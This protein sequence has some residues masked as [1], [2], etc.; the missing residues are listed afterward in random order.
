ME[1]LKKYVT[2]RNLQIAT[3]IGTAFT[4][5]MFIMSASIG[6]N[7]ESVSSFSDIG[8]LISSLKT[9]CN[10][11]YLDFIVVL[12]TTAGYAFRIFSEKDTRLS[13]K[14]LT[15]LNGIACL[16]GLI[17]FSTIHSIKAG[18]S[19]DF[20]SL[21]QLG[22]IEGQFSILRIMLFLQIAAGIAAAYFLFYKKE[23]RAEQESVDEEKQ[24]SANHTS[25][26]DSI[27][28][29]SATEK[30]KRNIRIGG[31]AAG[32]IIVLIVIV[33][34]Y[35][36]NRRTEIDLTTAC[37]VTF[38]GVSGSGSA[39]IHCSPDYDH[40]NEKIASF[41]SD[42]SYTIDNNGSLEN[43]T[44]VTLKANYSEA[45]AESSKINPVKTT[46]KYKVKGLEIAYRNFA[47]IPEKVSDEFEGAA[48]AFLEKDI[49]DVD[50]IFGGY[51][52]ITVEETALIGIYYK[53]GSYDNSGT[54]YYVFR[55]KETRE[56]SSYTKKEV[57]YYTV[58]LEN[59]KSSY[60]LDLSDESEDMIIDTLSI[61]ENDKTDAKALKQFTRFH[62]NVETVKTSPGSDIYKDERI[63]KQS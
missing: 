55:T 12:T 46:K 47:D 48:K 28:A 54:A 3:L 2:D 44:E 15:P 26:A 32:I 22:D 41:M 25:I 31:A 29:Y 59:I 14:V 56:R 19:G 23:H 63:D 49:Q 34:V 58:I 5:M 16:F 40:N 39:S 27:K 53:Y 30:G 24:A 62:T 33:N 45:T 13:I 20:A 10:I 51:D 57:N 37:T 8:S 21:M 60:K 52:S 6:S 36:S 50:G 43:G 35:E 7:S 38:E 18:L 17:C 4:I 42:V 9:F 11:F 1:T 61:Y